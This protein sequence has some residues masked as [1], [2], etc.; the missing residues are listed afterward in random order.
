VEKYDTEVHRE[1]T[2]YHGDF[3]K[4]KYNNLSDSSVFLRVTKKESL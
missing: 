3:I 4:T 1:N 2:E